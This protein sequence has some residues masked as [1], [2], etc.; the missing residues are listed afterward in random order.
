MC[1]KAIYPG[2]FDPFTLGHLDIIE[3]AAKLFDEI[4]VTIAEN[5]IKAPLFSLDERKT[6]IENVFQICANQ[7]LYFI[8]SISNL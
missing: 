8:L 3:R 4:I 5:S 6:F 7:E 1:Q 2:T